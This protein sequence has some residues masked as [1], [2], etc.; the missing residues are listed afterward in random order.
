MIKVDKGFR[1]IHKRLEFIGL[2]L[3]HIALLVEDEPN[4]RSSQI[5]LL[6]LGFEAPFPLATYEQTRPW[7]NARSRLS[8]CGARHGT[9]W[10][11]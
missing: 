11:S 3:R 4:G 6:L 7:A 8:F 9:Y 5:K 10:R 1:V 2:G